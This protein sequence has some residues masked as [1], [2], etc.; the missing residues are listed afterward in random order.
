MIA[1]IGTDIIKIE[2]VLLAYG[3]EAFRRKVYT[4]KEQEL[5]AARKVRAADNWAMKEAVV[6]ALGTGFG[7]IAPPEVELLRDA[8]GKPY[9]VL[10]G[11]ARVCAAKLGIGCVHVSVSNEKEYAV[12]FAVAVFGGNPGADAAAGEGK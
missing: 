6:K 1:G 5:V 11:A 9:C 4:P 7:K 3:R 12:A 8:A 10:H 2:R